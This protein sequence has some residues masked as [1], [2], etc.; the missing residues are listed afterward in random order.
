MSLNG[1]AEREIVLLGIRVTRHLSEDNMKLTKGRITTISVPFWDLHIDDFGWS[2]KTRLRN[3][4][5]P[6][7]SFWAEPSG[8]DFRTRHLGDAVGLTDCRSKE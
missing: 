5:R 7:F 2:W 1:S 3:L 8:N 6:G 4:R